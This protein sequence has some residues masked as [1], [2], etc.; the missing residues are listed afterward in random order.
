MRAVAIKDSEVA[1]GVCAALIRAGADP[2]EVALTPADAATPLR[3]AATPGA[4]HALLAAGA[5]PR[6]MA[7]NAHTVLFCPAALGHGPTCRALVA[8]GADPHARTLFGGHPLAQ[9]TSPCVVRAYLDLGVDVRALDGHT[10]LLSTC[11][12]AWRDEGACRALVAAGAAFHP[13]ALVKAESPG[14]VR[15]LL[16]A[17]ASAGAGVRDL[18]VGDGGTTPLF[19]PAALRY[20]EATRALIDAGGGGGGA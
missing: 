20:A 6:A 16:E 18:R 9:A 17:A 3:H 19:S 14:V 2:R 5:D 15:A 11:P 8:A 4:V 13:A 12:A 7:T 10:P 1:G